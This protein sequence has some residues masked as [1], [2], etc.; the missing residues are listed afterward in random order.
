MKTILLFL[1][2]VLSMQVLAQT[3]EIDS[4]RV[5]LS[6]SDKSKEK[7]SLFHQL[8]NAFLQVQSDS[9]LYYCQ[10]AKKIGADFSNN[11]FVRILITEAVALGNKG[12]FEEA[13]LAFI[14][15]LKKLEDSGRDTLLSRVENNFGMFLNKVERK[16]DAMLHLQKS[17]EYSQKLDDKMLQATIYQNIGNLFFGRENDKA[18]AYTNQA[19][20]LYERAPETSPN[21]GSSY[22]N[23]SSIFGQAGDMQGVIREAEKAVPIL[24]KS[25]N[26]RHLQVAFQN[27][28]LGYSV[29]E[30]PQKAIFYQKESLTLAKS[31][32]DSEM[33]LRAL[34]SVAEAYRRTGNY[35]EAIQYA[36]EGLDFENSNDVLLKQRQTILQILAKA[37]LGAGDFEAASLN[38][39]RVVELQDS[40]STLLAKEEYEQLE[41]AYKTKEKEQLLLLQNEKLERRKYLNW[42]IGIIAILLAFLLYF[43]WKNLQHR[44]KVNQQLEK[45]SKQLQSLDKA[46]SRFFTNISHELRTPLTLILAP[47]ENALQII[48]SPNA[49]TELK[50]AHSNGKKLLTLVNEILDLSKL[51][52]QEMKLRISP[53]HLEKLLRRIF[54]SY[55]SLAQVRGFILSFAYHLPQDLIVLLDANKF[56]KVLNNLLSNAFKYSKAGGVIT[57]RISAQQDNLKVE[58]QDT[59]KGISN[60][61]LEKIFDRFYQVEGE[62]EPLQG[63][64]GIGLAY[65][66]EIARFF[67]GDLKVESKLGQGSNFIFTFPMVK[68]DQV[69][70]TEEDEPGEEA[71][72]EE[73]AILPPLAEEKSHVLIVEDNPEM[74]RFL[75]RSLS[76]DF[77]CTTAQDGEKA[78]AKLET[79]RPD[80]IISDVMMPNMDGFTFLQKIKEKEAIRFTPIILL[81]ARALEADK[82]KGFALGVDDYL[83]KPFN[84]KELTARIWNLLRNKKVRETHEASLTTQST[85]LDTEKSAES[86]SHEER[87]VK[88]AE[89]FVLQ[90]LSDGNYKVSDLARDMTYSPRQLERLLKKMTGLSPVEFIREIR[91]QRAYRMLEERQFATVAEVRMEVGMENASYFSKKFRERFGINPGEVGR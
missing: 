79:E 48:K 85:D 49:K 35:E 25:K 71:M 12:N 10:R 6:T 45:Q 50:T 18:L 22:L 4:L 8:S 54:F 80:L 73:M 60:Q 88:S 47:L 20:E 59:G 14:D 58:V 42:T 16:E 87:F 26:N 72:L 44:K 90:H 23:R 68:S 51:E 29:L 38:F 69:S 57:M 32:N 11:D 76:G 3:T 15:I 43:L 53:V 77:H 9:S 70:L 91:L 66:R 62:D 83:T 67:D 28:T 34:I 40:L 31:L 55:H 64:T 1:A 82:L 74:S 46:K 17:L 63:G 13:E 21:L 24:K 30:Q 52:S 27:L 41:V 75:V 5:L 2:I 86:L 81:T 36:Q 65:A 89:D 56:E 84:T 19:I 7:L 39:D 33:I 61:E 37:Q 78:L